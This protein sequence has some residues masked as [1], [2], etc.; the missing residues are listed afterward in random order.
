M[1]IELFRTLSARNGN[2][3]MI[4]APRHIERVSQITAEFDRMGLRWRL[5]DTKAADDSGSD[6]QTDAIDGLVIVDTVGQL[7]DIYIAADLAFVGGPMVNLGGHNL[8]EPV[9]GQTPVL[10]GPHVENV[11]EAAAYIVE[12]NYGRQV[13]GPEQLTATV[14]QV[15]EGQLSFAVKAETDLTAS[16]TARIG[17]Y[18]LEM[19]GDV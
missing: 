12:N 16:T 1:L 8:L 6:S 4:I 18:L 3:I 11:R 15:Y 10:F 9:W 2:F 19:L 17:T 13:G 5:Y 7:N 14:E